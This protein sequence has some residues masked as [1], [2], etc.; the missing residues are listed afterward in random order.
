MKDK[1]S[2]ENKIKEE[3]N[4][5]EKVSLLDP[6]NRSSKKN[7]NGP[8]GVE[9]DTKSQLD[10]NKFGSSRSP[11]NIICLSLKSPKL[12]KMV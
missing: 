6:K 1:S 9:S 2:K 11:K 3:E 10:I 12:R 5:V 8:K 7:L 4:I